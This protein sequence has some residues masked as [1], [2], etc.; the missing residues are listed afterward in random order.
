MTKMGALFARQYERTCKECGYS[1]LVPRSIARRT[2]RGISAISVSGAT[3][4]AASV[5]TS[6]DL[7]AGIGARA[8]EMESYRIC[9]KCGVDDFSQQ[10]APKAGR[11]TSGA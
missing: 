7:S 5:R 9:A 10:P 4:G 2:W 11:G 6:A 1:W 8:D 3:R